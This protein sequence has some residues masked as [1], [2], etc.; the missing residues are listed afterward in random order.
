MSLFYDLMHDL[1]VKD[2][3]A[4]CEA[5]ED[6]LQGRTLYGGILAALSHEIACN[7]L[8][9][10]LPLRSIQV[11]Y[12]GPASNSLTIKATVLRQG[13]SVSYVSV[14]LTGDKG[15]ATRSLFCFGAA[16]SSNLASRTRPLP[17]VDTP[18]VAKPFLSLNNQPQFMKN[19]DMLMA[20]GD[21]PL[22][23]GPS[24]LMQVWVRH[25][26]NRAERAGQGGLMNALLAVAD[27]LPPAIITTLPELVPLSTMT[28]QVDVL[29]HDP[30]ISPNGWWLLESH[31][32]SAAEGYSAQKMMVWSEDGT[33]ILAGRQAVAV[34]S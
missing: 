15:L 20:G 3:L 10:P 24:A 7:S 28:W 22:S 8:G 30:V 23:Q 27:A 14:D 4:T 16:R 25:K 32:Q 18:Q 29:C 34:F 1:D 6:W 13:R 17:D 12:I 33:P 5:P 19:F 31:A 2:G 21:I 11:A 9:S 26:D